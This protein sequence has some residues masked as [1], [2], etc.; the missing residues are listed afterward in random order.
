MSE[1]NLNHRKYVIY[2]P[3][4]DCVSRGGNGRLRCS[5]E[6]AAIRLD[7]YTEMGV[8]IGFRIYELVPVEEVVVTTRTMKR[9]ED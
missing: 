6:E 4:E 8:R 9:I 5:A 2:S 1:H 7:M 3:T